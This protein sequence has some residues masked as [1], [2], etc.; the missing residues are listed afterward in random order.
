M[1]IVCPQCKSGSIV[2]G[3]IF[4]QADYVEPRACFRPSGLPFFAFVGTN[5]WMENK[6]FA[7][8][9]CG[10]IWTMADQ[11][12]LREILLKTASRY[13]Q[14]KPELNPREVYEIGK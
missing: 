10:T 9:T 11:K 7:C 14:K 6:F 13:A 12:K 4:N 1:E 8:S 3:K 5:V 2:E